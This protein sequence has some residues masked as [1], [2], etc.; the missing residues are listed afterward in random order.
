A[1]V[2]TAQLHLCEA[3]RVCRVRECRTLFPA[4][5][6]LDPYLPGSRRVT[7]KLKAAV[8]TSAI[9]RST[10]L[11][12]RKFRARKPPLSRLV[13]LSLRP[14]ERPHPT[15]SILVQLTQLSEVARITS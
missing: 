3:T 5:R 8:M 13:Q 7:R 12:T 11:K 9:S 6:R 15:A 1:V 4:C 10:H 2:Q 14:T